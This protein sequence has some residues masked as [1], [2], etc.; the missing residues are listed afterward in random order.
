MIPD[1]L[2]TDDQAGPL[3]QSRLGHQGV[4]WA[5]LIRLGDLSLP[6]DQEEAIGPWSL[7]LPLVE[8]TA[9]LREMEERLGRGSDTRWWP[10]LTLILGSSE[11]EH[12]TDLVR[13]LHQNHCLMAE[14]QVQFWHRIG[15]S[16]F[17]PCPHD[18]LAGLQQAVWRIP[19]R[20]G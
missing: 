14:T 17:V 1:Q 5:C 13:A 8:L 19:E 12:L 4:S 9:V 3:L 11:L 10:R 7:P 16:S 18:G 20:L 6:A 2:L 15:D